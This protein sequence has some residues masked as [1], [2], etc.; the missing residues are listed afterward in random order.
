M[1]DR[2]LLTCVKGSVRTTARLTDTTL[3]DSMPAMLPGVRP[4]RSPDFVTRRYRGRSPS[5][6]RAGTT[7][8]GNGRVATNG[9]S[10]STCATCW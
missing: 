5:S 6:S 1:P 2:P 9:S 7:V 3:P 8:T 4:A 10:P